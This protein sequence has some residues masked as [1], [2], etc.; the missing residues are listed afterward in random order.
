MS[1]FCRLKTEIPPRFLVNLK[2]FFGL[3]SFTQTRPYPDLHH[4]NAAWGCQTMWEKIQKERTGHFSMVWPCLQNTMG[5]AHDKFMHEFVTFDM[6][7][8]KT[9]GHNPTWESSLKMSLLYIIQVVWGHQTVCFSR[10]AALSSI[11]PS[12]MLCTHSLFSSPGPMNKRGQRS[13][14]RL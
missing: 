6:H 12:I 5:F 10:V 9:D 2:C 1:R 14:L 7:K 11:M 13:I 3:I 4:G 8:S